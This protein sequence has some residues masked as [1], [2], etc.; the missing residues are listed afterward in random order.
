V[1]RHS[2]APDDAANFSCAESSARRR[3]SDEIS[4][5]GKGQRMAAGTRFG[6]PSRTARSD[7]VRWLAANT[8][9]TWPAPASSRTAA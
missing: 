9:A 5:H 3:G 6:A 8:C 4:R 1:E 2:A 7:A